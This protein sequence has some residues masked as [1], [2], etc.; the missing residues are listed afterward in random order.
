MNK[1]MTQMIAVLGNFYGD[2][3]VLGIFPIYKEAKDYI[4]TTYENII[5][6]YVFPPDFSHYMKD[7]RWQAFSFGE[8]HFDWEKANDFF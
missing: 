1:K 5:F 7:F 4:K 3:V 8:V 6:D 2:T